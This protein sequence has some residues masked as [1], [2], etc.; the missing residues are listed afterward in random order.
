MKKPRKKKS[1]AFSWEGP[2]LFVK[3]LNGN[4]YIEHDEGGRIY[5]VKG[6]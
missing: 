2:F 3:Y 5:V 1:W 6:K 4:E